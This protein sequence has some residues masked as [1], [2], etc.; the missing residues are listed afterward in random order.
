MIKI[1]SM[2]QE[3]IKDCETLDVDIELIDTYQIRDIISKYRNKARQC[4]PDK[5]ANATEDEKKSRT[6]EFQE[7]NNA[8]ER[9]LKYILENDGN[10]S[11][12]DTGNDVDDDDE[13][14]FM[15]DNFGQFNFPK[16]NN[17][18]FTVIIQH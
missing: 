2:N 18:S 11:T 15:K 8:Y 14:K 6:A 16:E 9:I 10:G 4:H 5:F 3:L 1:A 7:L 17:G 13:E 12:D